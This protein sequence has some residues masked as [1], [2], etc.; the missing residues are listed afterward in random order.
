MDGLDTMAAFVKIISAI[1]P[2]EAVGKGLQRG[3]MFGAFAFVLRE[4]ILFYF[5]T[6]GSWRYY[7]AKRRERVAQAAKLADR[8]AKLE[9]AV[10]AAKLRVDLLLREL[11][12]RNGSPESASKPV[13]GLPKPPSSTEKPSPPPVGGGAPTSK[14]STG[15]LPPL[16]GAAGPIP[17]ATPPVSPSPAPAASGSAS[18]GLP[19]LPPLPKM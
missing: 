3:F 19:P 4:A 12:I 18:G 16:P 13:P 17:T 7:V 10:S 15:G 2:A 6:P 8:V 1:F 14:P 5:T 11:E 9:G